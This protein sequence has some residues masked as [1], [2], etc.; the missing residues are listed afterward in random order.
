MDTTTT[1]V[2]AGFTTAERDA[3]MHAHRD[4]S[5]TYNG[6]FVTWCSCGD[7]FRGIDPET[8]DYLH[9]VHQASVAGEPVG[10][11]D[12]ADAAGA[13]T[14]TWDP[15]PWANGH[16]SRIASLDLAEEGGEG[17]ERFTFSPRPSYTRHTPPDSRPVRPIVLRDGSPAS[18]SGKAAARRETP[19]PAVPYVAEG[20]ATAAASRPVT[21][22]GEAYAEAVEARGVELSAYVSP[23]DGAVVVHIDTAEATGRVRVNVNDAPVWDADPEE[24][25]SLITRD[26]D[27]F[28]AW[29]APGYV[30][31]AADVEWIA[32]AAGI[33]LR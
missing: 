23:E 17:G 14:V 21:A 10:S 1:T 5:Q 29:L 22:D 8:A 30:L 2:P 26:S 19:P 25:P 3:I 31:D 33:D 4:I 13:R 11:A 12:E 9:N 7:G 6:W 24:G 16:G 28:P 20:P 27:D 15:E 18:T 32:R